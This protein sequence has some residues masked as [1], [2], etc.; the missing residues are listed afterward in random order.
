MVNVTFISLTILHFKKQ[1]KNFIF[2]II[3][4]LQHLSIQLLQ[5][6]ECNLVDDIKAQG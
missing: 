2:F 4:Y 5:K 1:I 3:T 6:G